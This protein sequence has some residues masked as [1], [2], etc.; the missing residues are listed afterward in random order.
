MLVHASYQNPISGPFPCFPTLWKCF[1]MG[2]NSWGITTK[3]RITPQILITARFKV[4]QYSLVFISTRFPGG[5]FF[6]LSQGSRIWCRILPPCHLLSQMWVSRACCRYR[7]WSDVF[8][9]SFTGAR[10]PFSLAIKGTGNFWVDYFLGF[11][12]VL[13]FGKGREVNVFFLHLM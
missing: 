13:P 5:M 12:V 2:W 1:Q 8:N 6:P 11:E 10:K 4:T 9:P 7:C 3:H